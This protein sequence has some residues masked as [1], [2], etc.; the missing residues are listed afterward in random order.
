MELFASILKNFGH[1]PLFM[2][3]I[4]VISLVGAAV[5]YERIKYITAAGSVKKDELLNRVNH[6]LLAGSLDRAIS[7]C[8]QTNSPMTN[9]IKVGLLAAANLKSAEEVQTAMDAVAL[10]EIP[11]IEKRTSLLALL[12]NLSTLVGL[13]GTIAGLIGAF[14][15]V[16]G[17]SP[18]EKATLLSKSISM[19]MNCTA[20]GLL[21]AIP[22]LAVYGYIQ[23]RAQDLVDDVHEAA[24]VTLNFIISNR[25]K[26]KR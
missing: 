12:S 19:A 15:A 7:V 22:L 21:V 17:V 9:I 14:V 3:A 26:F 11:K 5:S 4:L 23:T 18:A 16:A 10:R 13:L 8:A 6:L 20:F 2:G 25:D 24:V 1:E